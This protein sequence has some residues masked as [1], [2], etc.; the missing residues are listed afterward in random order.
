M[1]DEDLTILVSSWRI[2][3][4]S[5]WL[6]TMVSKSPKWGCSFSKWPKWGVTIEPLT[7]PGMILQVE[8][9]TEKAPC[10]V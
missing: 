5:K 2:I 7:S 1:M 9:M 8:A 6:I 3:L 10:G 4:V